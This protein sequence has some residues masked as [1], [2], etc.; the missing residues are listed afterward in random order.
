M[1]EWLGERPVG[2]GYGQASQ[3]GGLE[4]GLADGIRERQVM[5]SP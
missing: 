2:R 3:G 4:V 5:E 1:I